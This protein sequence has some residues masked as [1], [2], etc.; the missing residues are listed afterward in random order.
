MKKLIKEYKNKIKLVPS[1]TPTNPN[2]HLVE[3]D[4]S[5][6]SD[7]SIKT[8][9]IVS[10]PTKPVNTKQLQQL[11]RNNVKPKASLVDANK[12]FH[13]I[14][15]PYKKLNVV[16]G[17]KS[18][19]F[20]LN[21]E[22]IQY[23]AEDF[24]IYEKIYYNKWASIVNMPL[25]KPKSIEPS[26]SVE[27]T[28]Q[29][30]VSTSK[31]DY[32]LYTKNSNSLLWEKLVGSN[33]TYNF[34]GIGHHDFKVIPKISM[35]ELPYLSYN[36][37]FKYR[38]SNELR[39]DILQ[40]SE[41][42]YIFKFKNIELNKY[43]LIFKNNENIIS[44]NFIQSPQILVSSNKLISIKD[45]KIEFYEKIQNDF[46][47]K[48]HVKIVLPKSYTQNNYNI[49]VSQFN[50]QQYSIE[51]EGQNLYQPDSN[52]EDSK[53]KA[54]LAKSKILV[55]NIKRIEDNLI[56]DY[57]RHPINIGKNKAFVYTLLN[58][59]SVMDIQDNKFEVFWEDS[60]A[61]RKYYNIPEPTS[62]NYTYN[63]SFEEYTLGFWDCIY[64]NLNKFI[65][66]DDQKGRY[67]FWKKEHPL[68]IQKNVIP[69]DWNNKT[70]NYIRFAKLDIDF[71]FDVLGFEHP[72]Y[73]WNDLFYKI[74]PIMKNCFIKENN[75]ID[76][77]KLQFNLKLRNN[78]KNFYNRLIS[79][80]HIFVFNS[81]NELEQTVKYKSIDWDFFDFIN[82]GTKRYKF[83]VGLVN[84]NI[85]ESNYIYGE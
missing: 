20:N 65:T 1:P 67:Y 30:I 73:S 24:S 60:E 46:C 74:D 40:K 68:M 9:N 48:Q 55:M 81:K 41:T 57:G 50:A 72:T 62:R 28:K 54:I 8:L 16:I 21:V 33:K 58:N 6:L 13:F 71:S 78:N 82:N 10:K 3:I 70:A 18:I 23:N 43:K 75:K 53:E 64:E 26:H 85:L 17:D 79:Y 45:L 7:E 19:K 51:V 2:R 44:T 42:E 15:A 47:Y 83:S 4:D 52:I 76:F 14:D 25:L 39:F 32:D 11:K 61:F 31:L 63:F 69:E 38:G 22:E 49:S 36:K 80:I 35:K 84:G 29:Q 77:I 34:V 37:Q 56:V 27:I 59:F 5:I 66:T 12:K